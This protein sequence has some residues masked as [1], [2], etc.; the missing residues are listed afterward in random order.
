MGWH[1]PN[2]PWQEFERALSWG[3]GW[4][5]DGEKLPRSVP[6]DRPAA[7][8]APT[9]PA[10]AELHCHSAYSFLDGAS[11]PHD[12]VA[13]AAAL[14]IEYLAMMLPDEETRAA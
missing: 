5:S 13:E 7:R 8:V 2:V 1:N 3:T 6:A 4:R 11:E 9:G 12:L 14:G 10:W